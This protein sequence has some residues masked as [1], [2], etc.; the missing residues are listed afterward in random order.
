MRTSAPALRLRTRGSR[1]PVQCVQTNATNA[2]RPVLRPEPPYHSGYRP[3]SLPAK[4][5]QFPATP[6]DSQRG[7]R[8]PRWNSRSWS[9]AKSGSAPRTVYRE[10][11]LLPPNPG[12]I[13]IGR[14]GAPKVLPAHLMYRLT[15]RLAITE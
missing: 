6:R 4:L 14:L 2:G 8:P 13:G 1:E 12:P 10:W 15:P 5:T 7:V 9:A 11:R 3:S